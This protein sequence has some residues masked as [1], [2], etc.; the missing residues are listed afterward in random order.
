MIKND[1]KTFIMLQ[2]FF[3]TLY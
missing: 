3:F 2:F 1:S